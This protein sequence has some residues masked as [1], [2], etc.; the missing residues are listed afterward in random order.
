MLLMLMKYFKAL[1][2]ERLLASRKWSR[3]HETRCFSV[4]CI[5]FSKTDINPNTDPRMALSNCSRVLFKLRRV[6]M[7]ELLRSR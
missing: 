7:P 5:K 3:L 6:V 1:I 2:R 4:N